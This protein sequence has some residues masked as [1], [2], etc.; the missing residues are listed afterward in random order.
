MRKMML[1]Q[2]IEDAGDAKDAPPDPKGGIPRQT[3]PGWIRWPI[4]LLFLPFILLDLCAQKIAK[5]LIKPPFK[6]VGQCLK[7]G[8]C[9]HYILIPKTKGFLGW[10]H[11]F[12]NQEINGFYFRDR[13]PHT[14]DDKPMYVM[15]CRYLQKDGSCKHYGLRPAVC[16]K[17][18]M[19]EYFGY[20]RVLKGCG[21]KAENRY[22]ADPKK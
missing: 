4:R 18:P 8:N 1:E 22:S 12:W 17:W 7:R 14:F 20:P 11:L 15:G 9:C 13:K 3:V 16:R 6:Q 19:I 2:L 5:L 21:F 10:L